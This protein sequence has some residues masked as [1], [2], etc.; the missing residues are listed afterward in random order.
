M[1]EVA[2]DDLTAGDEQDGRLAVVRANRTERRQRRVRQVKG[3]QPDSPD[4]NVDHACSVF[5]FAGHLGIL[6]FKVGS[7]S[8]SLARWMAPI[9]GQDQIARRSRIPSTSSWRPR[10]D[11]DSNSRG[12]AA[13][14]NHLTPF[15]RSNCVVAASPGRI[16]AILGELDKPHLSDNLSAGFRFRI[17]ISSCQARQNGGVLRELLILNRA[18]DFF[19][20]VQLPRFAGK[21][22]SFASGMNANDTKS[23][24]CANQ[25]NGRG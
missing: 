5:N 7:D 13:P 1:G 10:S 20:F 11:K 22:P 23:A 24:T 17:R 15:P 25:T 16:A 19:C 3:S 12:S 4:V 8:G 9:L 18:D 21:L 6:C 2:P 14:E